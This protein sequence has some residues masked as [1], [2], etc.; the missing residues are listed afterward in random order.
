MGALISVLFSF[1]V[2]VVIVVSIVVRVYGAIKGAKDSRKNP[3][4]ASG[5]VIR[6]PVKPLAADADD[7]WKPPELDEDDDVPAPVTRKPPAPKVAANT[8]GR[9]SI[10]A[11][12]PGAIAASV[13]DLPQVLR[14]PER[15]TPAVPEFFRRLEAK[16]LMQQAVILAEVLGPPKGME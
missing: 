4:Q 10:P 2:P 12:K 8:R 1:L 5:P 13:Y 11:I 9:P 7:D 14:E 16:P 3:L 15:E 6:P